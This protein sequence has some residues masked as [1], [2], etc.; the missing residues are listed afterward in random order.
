[1]ISKSLITSQ[2]RARSSFRN[3]I[4]AIFMASGAFL[5]TLICAEAYLRAYAPVPDPYET[6]KRNQLNHY[7]RSTFPKNFKM[8]TIAE[9]GLPGLSGRNLFSTNNVGFRGDHLAMPK[10]TKEY[11]V[12]LVGGSS[13][14]CFYLDD[15][16]SINQVLQE[17]MQKKQI[18]EKVVKVYN[19]GRSGEA[20]DDH[21]SMIAHR[22]IHMQPDV[23]IVFAGINDLT[24]AI[25]NFDYLHFDTETSA[26]FSTETLLRFLATEFQIPRRFYSFATRIGSTEER[27][28]LERI[29]Q[30][31]NYRTR[32]Q[33]ANSAVP[34]DEKPRVDLDPFERN[35]NTIIG[36]AEA[37]NVKLILMTQPSSWSGGDPVSRSWQWMRYRGRFAYSEKQMNM[38]LEA[39]NDVTRQVAKSKRVSLYDIA[40]VIPKTSKFFYDDVHFNVSGARFAG[41]GLSDVL[42]PIY[43][44]VSSSKSSAEKQ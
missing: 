22:I 17:A 16:Q 43:S 9:P 11:R 15:A 4:L 21:V 33:L 31:S 10:P 14:E 36:I 1:M 25:F 8:Y 6:Y 18:E 3:A 37:N 24:K 7:I 39:Y 12:F 27:T 34:T 44:G 23:I 29:T 38:A 13:S 5:L 28:L 19:A 2:T 41:L 42:A 35:L 32:V 30:T 26:R 20:L 40:R